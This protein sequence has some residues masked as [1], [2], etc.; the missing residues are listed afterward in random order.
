MIAENTEGVIYMA[1]NRNLIICRKSNSRSELEAAIKRKASFCRFYINGPLWMTYSSVWKVTGL[2]SFFDVSVT[3]F[4]VSSCH[5]KRSCWHLLRSLREKRRESW[6]DKSWLLY[7]DSARALDAQCIWPF[8]DE[9]KNIAVLEQPP[10]SLD[11]VPWDIS[12]FPKLKEIIKGTR[13]EDVVAIKRAV[14]RR[15]RVLQK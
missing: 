13:F 4:T 5:T 6:Q 1:N 3:S 7:S 12:L 8:L 11:L 14:R 9:K 10:N 2:G 15:Q